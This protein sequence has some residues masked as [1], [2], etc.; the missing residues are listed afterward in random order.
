M[1]VYMFDALAFISLA[2]SIC[3]YIYMAYV[4]VCERKYTCIHICI[5]V[6]VAGIH[7]LFNSSSHAPERHYKQKIKKIKKIK[8]N[9]CR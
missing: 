9:T 2:V 5:Y 6:Q 8:K 4:Y 1:H 3:T 7:W